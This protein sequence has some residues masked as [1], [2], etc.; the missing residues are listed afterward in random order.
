MILDEQFVDKVE[1]IRY[2]LFP[3]YGYMVNGENLLPGMEGFENVIAESNPN[4]IKIE[5]GDIVWSLLYS[6]TTGV[7][8]PMLLMHK[9]MECIAIIEVV[10]GHRRLG[11]T[12]VILKPLYC[13]GDWIHWLASLILGVPAVIQRDKI[14]PQAIFE[15][16]HG[17]EG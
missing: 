5:I 3:V 6:G 17:G 14:T 15:V 8:K 11:D 10:Q 2:Q 9:N 13:T 4:S 7:P 1:A 16:I 12:F